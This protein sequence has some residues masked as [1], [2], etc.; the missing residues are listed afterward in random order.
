[1]L[2]S[3]DTAKFF[4]FPTV[5]K[6]LLFHKFLICRKS[7]FV[8]AEDKNLIIFSSAIFQNYES[9]RINSDTFY[10]L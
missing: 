5:A 10:T 6:Y 1:M 7:K 4:I 8:F 2:L 3:K 9:F